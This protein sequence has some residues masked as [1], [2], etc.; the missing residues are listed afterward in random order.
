MDSA[1]T[2][3]IGNLNDQPESEDCLVLNVFTRSAAKGRKRPVMFWIH[4]GGFQAGSGSSP[5][6]DG[7][8]LVKRG[9]VV[10]VS[11][12]HRLNVFGFLYLGASEDAAHRTGNVGMLDIVLALQWVRDNI[13]QFGGDPDC[14]TIF[15]E[16]GGGRKVGT[17]L[18]MPDAK[19]L[20]QRAIIESGPSWR[21]VTRADAE[22][23]R[24]AV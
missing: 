19:G 22:R 23:A 13:E 14:V 16:S 20:F 5:G 24:D 8:N 6:Y 10:V 12:N 3:L 7:S 18:G 2:A 4:G 21:S 17:L 9:D 1:V 15:G 11:I